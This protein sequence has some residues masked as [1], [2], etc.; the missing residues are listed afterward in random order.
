MEFKP[1]SALDGVPVHLLDIYEISV[2]YQC[3]ID[4]LV[5]LLHTRTSQA[6]LLIEQIDHQLYE[7][8]PTQTSLESY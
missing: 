3:L 4:E 5:E 2:T 6:R 1:N 7:H 8:I